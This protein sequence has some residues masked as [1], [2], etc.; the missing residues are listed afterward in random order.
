MSWFTKGTKAVESTNVYKKGSKA[1]NLGMRNASRFGKTFKKMFT[2]EGEMMKLY[3]QLRNYY[4]ARDVRGL[5]KFKEYLES[6]QPGFGSGKQEKKVELVAYAGI[7][8]NELKGQ[9]VSAQAKNLMSA[10]NTRHEV[11]RKIK[12]NLW[13]MT[14]PMNN[15]ESVNI[16]MFR[17]PMGFNY[18]GYNATKS[19]RRKTRR[20]N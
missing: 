18:A 4:D 16:N 15:N 5:E 3:T 9:D 1:V 10:V 7:L 20:R 8:V 12:M 2:G 13:E 11:G 17:G 6:Y 14:H 19:R